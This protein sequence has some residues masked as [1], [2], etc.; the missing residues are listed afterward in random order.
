MS[1]EEILR[2]YHNKFLDFLVTITKNRFITSSSLQKVTNDEKNLPIQIQIPYHK[3]T[4]IF[5]KFLE[6]P[7]INFDPMIH[8][9]F[10]KNSSFNPQE[11]DQPTIHLI[12]LMKLLMLNR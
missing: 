5:F 2:N 3:M 11:I 7:E 4:R 12:G 6:I 10:E 8:S 9:S 1:K